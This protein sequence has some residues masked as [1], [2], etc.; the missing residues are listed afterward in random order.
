MNRRS[1]VLLGATGVAAISIPGACSYFGNVEYDPMLAQPQSL[2]LIWNTEAVK[3]IGNKY[4]SLVPDEKNVGSL[5][6]LLMKDL[7]DDKAGLAES[8]EEKI[9]TDFDAG[10]IVLVDGWVLSVSEA[11]QCALFSQ[12]KTK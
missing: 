6:N 4:R 12:S 8:L 3:T 10:N 7:S 5:V 2:S 9:K 1:F 11:R